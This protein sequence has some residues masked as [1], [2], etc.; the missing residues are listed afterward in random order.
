MVPYAKIISKNILDFETIECSLTLRAF[1]M[2]E[3]KVNSFRKI[4]YEVFFFFYI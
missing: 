3:N 4:K 2:N 1:E